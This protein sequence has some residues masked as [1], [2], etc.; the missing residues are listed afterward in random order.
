MFWAIFLILQII[1]MVFIFISIDIYKAKERLAKI[2]G[3]EEVWVDESDKDFDTTIVIPNNHMVQRPENFSEIAQAT[4]QKFLANA[5]SI[6]GDY[7]HY[8]ELQAPWG[9]IL[10]M[11]YSEDEWLIL[12]ELSE[13]SGRPI[14]HEVFAA[15][16]ARYGIEL[17]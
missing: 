1:I 7:V 14:E 15:T 2:L 4:M 3:I 13:K 6:E 8:I 16:I 9:D 12:K 10:P 17:K 5:E 11:V